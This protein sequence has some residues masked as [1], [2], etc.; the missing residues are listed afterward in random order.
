MILRNR[1]HI[2]AG[3]PN[4][5]QKHLPYAVFAGSRQFD[6]GI[7]GRTPQEFVRTLQNSRPV[8]SAG[9]ASLRAAVREIFE[10]LQ[11]L[12]DDVVRFWP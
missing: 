6:A 12:T 9:I 11:T 7:T 8:T 4:G 10:Y 1:F 5:R 3:Q 2:A